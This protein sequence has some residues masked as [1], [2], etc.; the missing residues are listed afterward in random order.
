MNKK[1]LSIRFFLFL[2]AGV[3]TFVASCKKDEQP[4]PVANFSFKATDL[5]VTFKDSSTNGTTYL[6]DFGDASTSTEKSPTHTYGDYGTYTVS[7][8]VTGAGGVGTISYDVEVTEVQPIT[9]D[10]KFDDWAN[11]SSIYSFPDGEGRTLLEAKVTDSK[12]FLYFYIKGTASIGEVLQVYVDADNTTTT[13]WGYWNWFKTPGIEYLMESVIVP[14]T[15]TEAS[16]VLKTATG[17]DANWPWEDFITSKAIYSS[18]NYVTV[19]SNKVIEFALL[20][21]MFTKPALGSKIRIVLCNSD[22]TWANVGTLPPK[23]T[24]AEPVVYTM[25]K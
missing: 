25:K 17:A 2:V 18:S 14:W 11:F 12:G 15:G 6:W 19:G 24:D 13:G 22:H 16:S 8:Q 7:L 21:D 9:I 23:E 1:E 10:G 5:A 20:K 4:K 3:M